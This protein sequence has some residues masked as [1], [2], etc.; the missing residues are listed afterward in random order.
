MALGHVIISFPNRHFRG[1]GRLIL[2]LSLGAFSSRWQ[3]FWSEK[4]CGPSLFAPLNGACFT[5]RR[6]EKERDVKEPAMS[7][8]GSPTMESGTPLG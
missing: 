5:G 1:Q 3:I 4:W 2:L 7:R 6:E 8:S